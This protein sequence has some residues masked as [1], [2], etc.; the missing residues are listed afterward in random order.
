[1]KEIIWLTPKIIPL[2]SK[3]DLPLL[4]GLPMHDYELWA[5][6]YVSRVIKRKAHTW[7]LRIPKA[8]PLREAEKIASP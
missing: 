8:S 4:S 2:Y 7:I 5:N 3:T 1:M 6:C